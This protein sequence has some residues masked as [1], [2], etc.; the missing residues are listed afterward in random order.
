MESIDRK[1]VVSATH[2][3]PAAPAAGLAFRESDGT[4]DSTP[5]HDW[6]ELASRESDGLEVSLLWSRTADRVKVTL[7]DSRLEQ[8]FELDV[9]GADALA[10]FLHPFAYATARGMFLGVAARESIDSQPMS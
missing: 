3:T 5:T 10:A 9:V 8:Q 2:W 7:A 1:H 6:R 4:L